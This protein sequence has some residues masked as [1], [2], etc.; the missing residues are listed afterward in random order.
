MDALHIYAIVLAYNR[1]AH[2]TSQVGAVSSEQ[3]LAG[4]QLMIF[5]IL[6]VVNILIPDRALHRLSSMIC[7]S[8]LD[9][10]A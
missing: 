6:A 10:E 3:C 4:E 2:L 7:V 8:V 5:I 1:R 9:V